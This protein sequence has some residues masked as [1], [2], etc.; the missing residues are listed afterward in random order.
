MP[1]VGFEATTPVFRQAKIV[2]AFESAAT[3][4]DPSR[5]IP[6]INFA[7]YTLESRLPAAICKT[8]FPSLIFTEG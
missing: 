5:C 7:V 4:T 8:D 3:V 6:L 1:S 2:H